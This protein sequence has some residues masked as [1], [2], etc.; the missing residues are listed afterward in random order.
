MILGFVAPPGSFPG[1]DVPS[2]VTDPTYPCAET[3]TGSRA[4]KEKARRRWII[5]N[6]SMRRKRL[7]SRSNQRRQR[8]PLNRPVERN[9]GIKRVETG[10]QRQ[11]NV[12]S[13]NQRVSRE[14]SNGKTDPL[15]GGLAAPYTWIW[16]GYHTARQAA[17]R[18][19]G[20]E[21][22]SIAAGASSRT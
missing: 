1:Y 9:K 6:L 10:G 4:A 21:A 16:D 18:R 11:I 8:C 22:Q 15:V 5:M 12:V 19:N 20:K 2:M 13:E 7:L 14:L 3:K 17:K